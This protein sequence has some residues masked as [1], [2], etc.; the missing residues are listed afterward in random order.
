VIPFQ[1]TPQE[2]L[3]LAAIVVEMGRAGLDPAF[4]T[5]ASDLARLDQG[6]YD[7]MAMWSQSEA[8]AEERDEIIADLQELLDDHAE[9][10]QTPLRR[11]YIKYEHLEEIAAKVVAD[12]ARLRRL[13]E[14]HGGVTLVAKKSGIPQPSLSRLL[15]SASIPRRTTLYKIANALDLPETDVVTDWTR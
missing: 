11:P 9:A 15:N 8:D 7:L 12:K 1:T 5:A 10:P 6:A 4:I 13:I 3:K 2:V 14:Q